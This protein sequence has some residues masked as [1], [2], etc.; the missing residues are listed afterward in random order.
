M[1]TYQVGNVATLTTTVKNAAG[2]ATDATMALVVT[3]PDGTNPTTTVTHVST[4]VYQ[5]LVSVTAAGSWTYK[6]T[7]SGTV[8]AVDEGS[9]FA[10]DPAP[11]VYATLTEFRERLN[12]TN[13]TRD[14]AP[15]LDA[16]ETASRDVDEDTGR[17]F[18]LDLT[19]S[20]RTYMETGRI[21][22]AREGWRLLIDDIGSTAGLVVEYGY[23]DT[24]STITD[25]ETGPENALAHRRPVTSLLRWAGWP[26]GSTTRIRVT[27]RW[28][29][30]VVP[31]QIHDATLLR[32]H[33]L[34]S[35]R[36]AP[37]GVAGFGDQGPV[38]YSRYDPDYDQLIAPF[39]LPGFG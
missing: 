25:Y 27:A 5:A 37:S 34:Y 31:S 22:R 32:A 2:A 21:L 35:R 9:F 20:A 24:W 18:W 38:R 28:G 16:L 3:A 12:I 29:W 7:A 4:G 13:A 17:R 14:D 33:R 8:S 1:T 6:W 30:P 26:C 11:L 10:A 39:I 36:E 19:T 15:L 23:G